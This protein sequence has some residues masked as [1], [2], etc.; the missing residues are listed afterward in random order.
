MKKISLTI[1]GLLCSC[2]LLLA[3]KQTITFD[4]ERSSFN[5]D[6][7][8]PAEK[9]FFMSGEIEG[10]TN[11]VE[12]IIMSGKRHGEHVLYQNLWKRSYNDRSQHFL[13]PINYYLRSNTEYDFLINYYRKAEPWEVQE[14]K[15]DMLFTLETY[16]GQSLHLP[17]RGIRKMSRISLMLSEMQAMTQ[18]RLAHYRFHRNIPFEGFSD[19]VK[20]KLKIL[21]L[22][23]SETEDEE[24][25]IRQQLGE[26]M[27]LIG[28]ELNLHMD[29]GLSILVDSREISKYPTEKIK[30]AMIVHGGYGGILLQHKLEG[31]NNSSGGMAGITLPLGKQTFA[32]QLM[33]NTAVVAG[34]YFK[35][36]ENVE[37]IKV[38]GPIV[39][40]PLYLGLG[41]QLYEF[42]RFS[43]GVT[44]LQNQASNDPSSNL[45]IDI[46]DS[47]YFR[48]FFGITADISF[49]AEFLK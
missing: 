47:I 8:L 12:V 7:P 32:P 27:G 42:I 16:V 29:K 35:D 13:L 19:I 22:Q 3:Q 18:A 45:P 38:S 2:S 49:K 24:Q 41:Y 23:P 25:A 46:D 39:K 26:L 9:Y 40:R 4:Y 21:Y 5:M 15:N 6:Q 33:S 1:L 17:R 31:V 43:G 44:I 36:F 48:P 14:I 10:S 34:F 11:M 37:G 30:S 28:F 20:G